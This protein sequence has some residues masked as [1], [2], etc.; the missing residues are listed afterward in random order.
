M[1]NNAPLGELAKKDP[2]NPSN[3]QSERIYGAYGLWWDGNALRCRR[4]ALM[5]IE[6]DAAYPSMWRV[7]LPTGRPTDMLNLTRAK[8]Y[9]CA[10][11]CGCSTSRCCRERT[12]RD[13]LGGRPG[14][15]RVRH[16]KQMAG[17]LATSKRAGAA[18]IPY[19]IGCAS[20]VL[21]VLNCI[22]K[23]YGLLTPIPKGL[24]RYRTVG[25]CYANCQ[26][27]VLQDDRLTY[28][29]GA[30]LSNGRWVGHAW[31]TMDGEHAIDLTWR[32]Q[33]TRLFRKDSGKDDMTILSPGVEYVGIEIPREAIAKFII[34]NRCQGVFLD[35]W[36]A[37]GLGTSEQR[38]P[39]PKQ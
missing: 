16:A 38:S 10:R 1:P 29:E 18:M 22:G 33:R 4:R 2:L 26:S 35:Q 3:A 8:D 21:E 5:S 24:P 13:A 6:P 12:A 9:A 14:H 27:A 19:A 20:N 37:E 31:V 11:H 32:G 17:L 15:F 23:R 39:G 34:E 25:D 28:V 36:I 30:A 7:R